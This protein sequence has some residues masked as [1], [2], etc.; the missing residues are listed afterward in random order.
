M[1]I[2]GLWTTIYIGVTVLAFVLFRHKYRHLRPHVEVILKE[3][4]LDRAKEGAEIWDVRTEREWDVTPI[5]GSRQIS[6]NQLRLPNPNV[7]VICVCNSGIRAQHAA[8]TL[9]KM[10][11]EKVAW[12]KGT[13]LDC[14]KI[15]NNS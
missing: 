10:G 15:L 7:S 6:H 2:V 11:H 1:G 8:E 12:F 9:K 3:Q 5:K 13:N 14:V 4:L